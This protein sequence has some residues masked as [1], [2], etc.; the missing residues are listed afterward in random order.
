VEDQASLLV[1]GARGLTG[2]PGLVLGSVTTSLVAQPH[3]PVVVV[4]APA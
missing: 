2:L 3:V 4:P 1:L